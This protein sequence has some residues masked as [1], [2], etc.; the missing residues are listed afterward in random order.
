MERAF[1]KIDK[2]LNMFENDFG[3]RTKGIARKIISMPSLSS[4]PHS[5][6]GSAAR[7]KTLSRTTLCC[8]KTR[9]YRK[10]VWRRT[11][12]GS[13]VNIENTIIEFLFNIV[14]I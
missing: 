4:K 7:K 3:F 11:W 5:A 2:F 10:R 13:A 1:N 14:I 6:N 8:P 12:N 9:W